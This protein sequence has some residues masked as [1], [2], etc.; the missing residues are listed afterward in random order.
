MSWPTGRSSRFATV[1]Q[2]DLVFELGGALERATCSV[3]A[4]VPGIP[5]VLTFNVEDTLK[6]EREASRRHNR[7]VHVYN[8]KLHIHFHGACTVHLVGR[9]C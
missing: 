5:E 7:E 6:I 1:G 4:L 2:E 3:L 9:L 8:G